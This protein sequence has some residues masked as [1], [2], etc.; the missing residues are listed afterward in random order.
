MT[1]VT[2]VA[3]QCTG[4]L[5]SDEEKSAVDIDNDFRPADPPCSLLLFQ[6]TWA[7]LKLSNRLSAILRLMEKQQ[8][9]PLLKSMIQVQIPCYFEHQHCGRSSFHQKNINTDERLVDENLL[10]HKNKLGSKAVKFFLIRNVKEGPFKGYTDES[11]GSLFFCVFFFMAKLIK[12]SSK[13]IHLASQWQPSQPPRRSLIL[14][15]KNSGLNSRKNPDFSRI[16]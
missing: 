10:V 3:T 15:S 4:N 12:S 2:A 5:R 13:W 9:F 14:S 8:I 16:K 6:A 11:K 1:Q 7:I